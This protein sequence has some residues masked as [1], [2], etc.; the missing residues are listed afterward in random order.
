[1]AIGGQSQYVNPTYVASGTTLAFGT[2]GTEIGNSQVQ[3]PG[4]ATLDARGVSG[5]I[6][7]L[8]GSGTLMNY[9]ATTAGTVVTGMDNTNATFSGAIVNPFPGGLLN[10]TKVGSGNFNLSAN[11]LGTGLNSPN[12]GTLTVSGGSVTLNTA[13][14]MVGFT[15]YTL[16]ANG[17]LT[18]D[19]SVNPVSNRLGGSYEL[20]A[21]NVATATTTPRAITFQGGV[22]N[23]IGNSGVAVSENLGNVNVSN[24]GGGVLTLS[25]TNTAGINMAI[26]GAFSGQ[27]G[28]ATLLIRGD[29][30]GNSAGANTATITLSNSANLPTPSVASTIVYNNN[31]NGAPATTPL[32]Q[33]AGADGTVTMSIR[34]DILVDP[35]STGNGVSFAVRDT[36][37]GLLRPLASSEYVSS[38]G[39]LTSAAGNLLSVNYITNASV[40]APQVISSPLYLNSLVLSGSASLATN[41]LGGS[42]ID[43]FLFLNSGGLLASGGTTSLNSPIITGGVATDVHVAGASTVLNV[44]SPFITTTSGLVKADGGTLVFNTPQYYS[45]TP[46]TQVNG[47]LLQLN[48]GNNTILAQPTATVPA[49]LALG[50]NGGT[51]DLDGNSQMVGALASVNTLPGTGGTITNSSTAAVNF[52]ANSSAASTFAG[53]IANGAGGLSFYKQGA[54][55]LTLTGTSTYAGTTNVEGGNLTLRDGGTLAN[56]SAINV[57]YATFAVDNTGLLDSTSRVP[58]AAPISL[59]K[60][61]LS[62]TGRQVVETMNLGP[63]N[64]SQG[65]STITINPYNAYAASGGG[66]SL[67]LAN[68]TQ[69]PASGATVNFINGGTG[70]V[71]IGQVNNPQIFI[72]GSGSATA[73]GIL[74]GWAIYNSASFAAYSATQGVG[75][76][77]AAGFPAYA[78]DALTAGVPTDNINTTATTTPVT[79]RTINSLS[80]N[81][82]AAI[83][84]TMNSGIDTLTIGTGGLLEAA[85]QAVTI[86]G[87]NITSGTA[88]NTLYGYIAQNTTTINSTLANN[89]SAVSLVKAGG[90]TM[91]L[92]PVTV[93]PT[94]AFAAS[95]STIT[96]NGPSTL[97]VGEGV[98][99]AGIA[100][101]TTISAISGNVITLSAITTAAGAANTNLTFAP[102]TASGVLNG[103]TMLT[104]GGTFAPFVG[105]VVGG[106]GIPAGT[107]VL[108]VAGSSGAWVL[109]L[110]NAAT[111]SAASS[112][113]FGAPSSAYTGPTFVN[114]GTLNLS[115]QV[116]SVVVPGNLTINGATATM[117]ANQGQIAPT[118]NVTLGGGGVLTL[119]GSNVL[120]SVSFAG[121][122]GNNQTSLNI[123]GGLLTL[124]ATNAVTAQN[125]NTANTPQITGGSLAFASAAATIATSG[126]ST[127]SLLMAAPIVSSNG[128]I[129]VTGTGAVVF[130]STGSTFT[131]GVN[132]NSGSIILAADSTPNT[133]GATVTSGPLGTGTL[134]TA[135]GATI[136]SG[137]GNQNLSNAVTINGNLNFGGVLAANNVTLNGP[138]TLGGSSPTVTVNSPMVTTNINGPLAGSSLTKAGPGSLFLSNTGNSPSSVTINNGTLGVYAIAPSGGTPLG[139]STV[140]LNG[141]RLTLQGQ[142]QNQGL[143]ADFYTSAASYAPASYV[144]LSTLNST[145]TNGTP[146]LAVP[147]TMNGKATLNYSN[148]NGTTSPFNLVNSATTAAYGFSPATDYGVVFNG[149][150]YL[151]TPGQ[152][153]FSTYSDD[154]SALWIGGQNVAVVNNN[155]DQAEALRTGIYE[156]TAPGWYPITIGYY[157]G[158]G[159]EVMEAEYTTPNGVTQDIPNSVLAYA[160]SVSQ[161]YVNNV[162]VTA[163]SIIDVNNSLTATMGSLAIGSNTLTVTGGNGANLILGMVGLSGSATFAPIA[164]TTLTLGALNDNGTARTITTTNNGTVALS[165]VAASL[166]NGTQFNVAGGTLNPTVTGA[167]GSLSQI[168]V[169]GSGTLSLGASQTIGGLTNSGNVLLN[170]YALTVGAANNLSSTFSGVIADGAASGI[171]VTGGTGNFT[172]TG[173]NTYSG[174]TTLNSGSL[175]VTT[176]SLP[177]GAGVT[178]ASAAAILNF[179]QGFNGAYG[180]AISGVSPVVTSGTGTVALTGSSNYTAGTFVNAGKLIAAN[181][182]ALGA[183]TVTV[184]GG[185]L[186]LSSYS[187][188]SGF[189]VTGG[190]LGSS[191]WDVVSNGITVPAI[192]NNVLTL[193]QAAVNQARSAFYATPVNP[194]AGFTANFVYQVPVHSASPANGM[195]FVIQDQGTGAIGGNGGNLGYAGITPSVA[196]E[197]NL[198]PT[199]NPGGTS[200]S[201]TF[202]GNNGSIGSNTTNTNTTGVNVAGSDPIEVTVAYNPAAQTMTENLLDTV[203]SG[204]YSQ[205]WTGVSLSGSTNVYV[206]FTGSTGTSDAQ[207]LVSNFSMVNSAY[208]ATAGTTNYFRNSVAIP[209]GTAQ[210][211]TVNGLVGNLNATGTNINTTGGLS[212]GAGSTLNLAADSTAT[213]NQPYA[214]TFAGPTAVNRAAT[215]NVADNGIGGG[216][217][218][219]GSLNDGGSPAT[220]NVTGPGMVV[221]TTSAASLVNGTQFNVSQGTLYVNDS[222][223]TVQ[224]LGAG[225][226]AIINVAAGATFGN[227]NLDT[228][229][230]ALEGAGTVVTFG[231]QL[232][233]G[234]SN[235]LSSTFSGTILDGGYPGNLIKGGTGVLALTGSSSYSGQ[236]IVNAGALV[237]GNGTNGSA[238]GSS[239][240]VLNGGTL[241]AGPAGGAMGGLVQAGAAVHTIAPGGGLAAGQYGTLNLVGGLNTNN[242]TT[243]TFNLNLNSSI[244]VGL[245]SEP[246]YGGDLINLAGSVLSVSGGSITFGVDPGN[247]GDYR[248]FGNLGS[249]SSNVTGFSLPIAPTGDTYSLSTT[250][251]SGYLD[252][253]VASTGTTTFSG[254]ATWVS[255]GGTTWNNSSNWQD[256]N[257]RNGVPGTASRPSDTAAF[258]GSSSVTAI[259]LDVNP[260]LAA[261]SFSNSNYTLSGDTL[262]LHSGSGTAVVTV[263][264]GTQTIASALTLSSSVAIAPAAGSELTI[265]GNIGETPSG[266]ALSLTGGGTLV[267]AGTADSYTGGTYVDEGTLYAQNSGSIQ[268]GSRLIVGAGGMFLYDPTVAGSVLDPVSVHASLQINPVPEPGTLA[269]LSVAGIVAAAAWRRKNNQGDRR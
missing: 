181:P 14:A 70:A 223:N 185:T 113:T 194:S 228:T 220:I 237:I 145:V 267:L 251:D 120:N 86:N 174:G 1:M 222:G 11:N 77:G 101:G 58:A 236:T 147:T 129:T 122:G 111:V 83:S 37:S 62:F 126:L 125:D 50:V 268:D 137:T 158:T 242:Y 91:T 97:F 121:I 151:A 244:G 100:A 123:N 249:S 191:T 241:A 213:A 96:L 230:G 54:S 203:T 187:S 24:G 199:N 57:N 195:T 34:P 225:T 177:S 240:V 226:L 63:V 99:G 20:V 196:V 114:N 94:L 8:T 40:N 9:N 205:T 127:N 255:S 197:F 246:V 142:F 31:G 32:S 159:N 89:G 26:N 103:T 41:L 92:D 221:L 78:T 189:G 248:L 69:T 211:V 264:S 243:L 148:A 98:T 105:M 33:G 144:N 3:L 150:I 67:Q 10:L 250:A 7:S 235:N 6:G 166:V 163:N 81:P 66:L 201:A 210:T 73:N 68:L 128:A 82:A 231:N 108:G 245:N 198:L 25:A 269:L 118:S 153:S 47:G 30:L 164:G 156:N 55:T 161:T 262:T 252:L 52:I 146:V 157:Q 259:T 206:G 74:G 90:G 38:V 190:S 27:N 192:T 112:L 217:L 204:T 216:R 131:N 135:N 49:L 21:A 202:L 143:L 36:T 261:L 160:P 51:L 5:T 238:T 46:G 76:L 124:S 260:S 188:V 117:N 42:G 12:L 102:A 4:G 184:N 60:G 152:Y 232:Y 149:Y 165:A 116:G 29:N 172:L 109:T 169:A 224:S 167:M 154:G 104:T 84:V 233:V 219:V 176:N 79:T 119:V 88:G 133:V 28:Y 35:S 170:G 179:N 254:S 16:N 139:T 257:K 15:G 182:S 19:D 75:G 178:G 80:L 186:S 138:V 208:I 256:G 239:V 180:G 45:G 53:P 95:A 155:L 107:V 2:A 168:S 48:G 93:A 229:I 209:A 43:A 61:A 140:T 234:S 65:D 44:N 227:P 214:L 266:E 130:S 207:Q 13:S 193:T 64:A 183:G 106:T 39:S 22:L 18:V 171:L 173:Y 162:N 258:S 23:V 215:F 247:A 253:V 218:N 115:G 136:L 212:L 263:T 87:G 175:T 56:T 17:V 71:T 85:S 110:N 265:F 59:S 141:G 72:A 134:T 132:L 200:T